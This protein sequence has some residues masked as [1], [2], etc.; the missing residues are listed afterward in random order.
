MNVLEIQQA[1]HG[2]GF[3]PG[4]HDGIRG[5]RTIDAIEA[6]QAANGLVADGIVGP[7]TG[8]LLFT[9]LKPTAKPAV[10]AAELPWF[11]EAWDLVGTRETRG[12]GSNADIIKWA[13]DLKIPYG[14]DEVPWCGL[15]VAHCIG[16][17]LVREPLPG[18]PLW[19]RGWRSFGNSVEPQPGAL[20]VFWRGSKNGS[21]GHVGFYAGEEKG[22]NG[23]YH[24]LGG[25][26]SDRVSVT[27]V[28]KD[29]LLAARWPSTVPAASGKPN[30]VTA[31]GG[32]LS[33]NE[34]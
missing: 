5:R 10:S 14:D 3:D 27:R 1:L 2:K 17:Q 30:F 22:K 8:K 4:S 13:D 24:V 9:T 6:F 7:V 29:R 12:S 15:F 25:N 23:A 16:S 18:A 21:M 28:A 34:A 33:N 32:E 26:Q 11:A 20:L 19:A 31:N